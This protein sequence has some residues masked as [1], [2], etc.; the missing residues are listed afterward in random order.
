MATRAKSRVSSAATNGKQGHSLISDAKFRQLYALVLEGRAAA[1]GREAVLAAVS[2]DLR[3]GDALLAEFDVP[4]VAGV[5]LQPDGGKPGTFPDMIVAAI[6]AAAADRMRGNRRVTVLFAPPAGAEDTLLQ[7]HAIAGAAR[8]PVLFVEDAARGSKSRGS[9]GEPDQNQLPAIP[10][11][12]HDVIALYRVAHESIARAREGS[13]PTRL[14]CTSWPSRN[15]EAGDPVEHL[16]QWLQS[17]GLP[18]HEWRREIA[19]SLHAPAQNRRAAS[20]RGKARASAGNTP[21]TPSP[22]LRNL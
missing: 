10:V 6:S 14:L 5:A 12:A 4:P 2:A 20:P 7:A 13:G 17:R 16:E 9:S 19:A 8:L 15:G 1:A 21:R 11:D 3:E 18:A 22:G